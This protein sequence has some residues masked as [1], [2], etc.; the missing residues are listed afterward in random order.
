MHTFGLADK[1]KYASALS[2]WSLVELAA[3]SPS[4]RLTG[5]RVIS[6]A[7]S[8]F[9]PG[10]SSTRPFLSPYYTIRQ[11][12]MGLIPPVLVS[13]WQVP[14]TLGRSRRPSVEQ[15]SGGWV[16]HDGSRDSSNLLLVPIIDFPRGKTS[17]RDAA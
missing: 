1:D 5:T 8:C 13:R 15:V 2:H 9:H 7:S 4:T 3:R 10:P 16:G 11:P 17:P 6:V 14:T 12:E